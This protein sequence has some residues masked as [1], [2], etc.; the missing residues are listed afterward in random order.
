MTDA[1]FAV[2]L[3]AGNLKS[4]DYKSLLQ[5][6]SQKRFQE[7]PIYTLTGSGGPEHAKLFYVKLTLPDGTTYEDAAPSVKKAEQSV[8]AMALGELEARDAE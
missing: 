2:A 3:N 8:A 4:K 6:L 7:F 1:F 5:A